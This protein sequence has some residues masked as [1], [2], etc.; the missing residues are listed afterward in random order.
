MQRGCR[1]AG[2]MTHPVLAKPKSHIFSMQAALTSRLDGL[3]SRCMT[4]A[5]WMY[6][7]PQSSCNPHISSVGTGLASLG[8]WTTASVRG[9]CWCS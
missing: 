5:L 3:R 7:R 6:L 1:T 8:A 2:E 4:F 9:A